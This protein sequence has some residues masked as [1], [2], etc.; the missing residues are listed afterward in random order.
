[1]RFMLLMYPNPEAEAGRLPT[2][3]EV[4]A[5]GTFNQAMM[6][7]GVLLAADGLQATSKGAR[8]RFGPGRPAVT[9]GP[10]AEAKEIVGGYWMIRVNSREEAVGWATRC[11]VH[12]PQVFVE[13]RQVFEMEDF[14]ADVQAAAAGEIELAAR[15]GLNQQG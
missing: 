10:F 8:V 9:D 2:A 14:P 15:L 3:E 6:E 5:M 11:P 1:M 4:A 12:D 13:V 7:A